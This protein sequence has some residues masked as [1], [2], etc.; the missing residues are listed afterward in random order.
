MRAGRAG[1]SIFA[2]AC[3]GAGLGWAFGGAGMGALRPR[4]ALRDSPAGYL[5]MKDEGAGRRGVGR[6]YM[7]GRK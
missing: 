2:G 5:V 3:H 6:V 1:G 7:A 4:R